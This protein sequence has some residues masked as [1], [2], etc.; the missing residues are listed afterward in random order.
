MQEAQMMVRMINEMN[1][2]LGNLMVKNKISLNLAA[3]KSHDYQKFTI[4][5]LTLI[6]GLVLWLFTDPSSHPVVTKS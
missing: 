6:P 2:V 3:N 1:K 4:L 5:E